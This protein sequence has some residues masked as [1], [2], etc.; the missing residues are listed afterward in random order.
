MWQ[1]EANINTQRSLARFGTSLSHRGWRGYRAVFGNLQ[2]HYR[3]TDSAISRSFSLLQLRH[4]IRRIL[5]G[6][7]VVQYRH[8]PL[9]FA[10][11]AISSSLCSLLYTIRNAL[12][13]CLLTDISEES[14][15]N[16]LMILAYPRCSQSLLL[17]RRQ[18]R[19]PIQGRERE[20]ADHTAIR[21]FMKPTL[22]AALPRGRNRA[23]M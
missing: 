11:L 3:R 4:L 2:G 8:F 6:S 20:F 14:F 9:N 7:L 17:L 18:L 23:S 22:N 21:V 16:R 12:S 5:S 13:G 15:G 19:S 10:G 1:R